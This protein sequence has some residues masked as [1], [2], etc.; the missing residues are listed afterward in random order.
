VSCEAIYDYGKKELRTCTYC[1][2]FEILRVVTIYQGR[3]SEEKSIM[4]LR[5]FGA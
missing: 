1:H 3:T 5:R 4:V 2:S